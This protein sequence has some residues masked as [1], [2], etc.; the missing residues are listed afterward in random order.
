MKKIISILLSAVFLLSQLG[1]T[2][3]SHYCGGE[4]I[5]RKIITGSTHLGC[6]VE[7]MGSCDN[8][9]SSNDHDIRISSPPCCENQYQTIQLSDDILS[10]IVR[11]NSN[12]DFTEVFINTSK[13]QVLLSKSAQQFY[14]DY[15]PPPLEKDLQMLFRSFL[16]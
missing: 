13:I 6:G 4:I 10:D 1:F 16:I 14:A 11:I 15:S 5:E 3:G 2:I 12:I 9:N 8:N 7:N